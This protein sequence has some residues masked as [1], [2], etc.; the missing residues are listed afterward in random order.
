MRIFFLF[1]GWLFFS[2][3]AKAQSL[4]N[5]NKQ[6]IDF[7][8][9]GDYKKALEHAK[10]ALTQAPDDINKRNLTDSIAKL[11]KGISIN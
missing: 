5:L 10:L 8:E 11:E 7:Y 3:C 9:K 4:E 1:A 6:T 2:A